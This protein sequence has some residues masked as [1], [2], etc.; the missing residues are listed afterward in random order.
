MSAATDRAVRPARAKRVRPMPSRAIRDVER[1]RLVSEPGQQLAHPAGTSAEIEDPTVVRQVEMFGGHEKRVQQPDVL[2][3]V[4]AGERLLQ[5]ILVFAV[6][7]VSLDFRSRPLLYFSVDQWPGQEHGPR[8]RSALV[9]AGTADAQP[10]CKHVK[11]T[12]GQR[13]QKVD[14]LVLRGVADAPGRR[15][16][17]VQ[18]VG[19]QGRHAFSAAH[20][21]GGS[22]DAFG[23]IE[24]RERGAQRVDRRR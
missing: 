3:A 5:E 7:V 10:L 17:L 23:A 19:R 20:E 4:D 11:M 18:Q 6:G 15:K 13:C 9:R 22:G 21:G 24:T 2:N 14:G 1:E 8:L 12:G 16:R